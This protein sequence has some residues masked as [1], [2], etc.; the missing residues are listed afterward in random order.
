M[1]GQKVLGIAS[2]SSYAG[3]QV[4]NGRGRFTVS[5][6]GGEL[7]GIVIAVTF[8]LNAWLVFMN[9]ARTGV[10][11]GKR[12]S[13]LEK[14]HVPE[15]LLVFYL[16][17]TQSRGPMIALAAGYPILQIPKFKNTKVGIGVVAVVLTLGALGA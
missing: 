12:I 17:L 7:A 4:R 1:I 15:L 9:K 6:G 8:S 14:Y 10:D 5:L 16:W 3:I 11:L 13:K 2:C